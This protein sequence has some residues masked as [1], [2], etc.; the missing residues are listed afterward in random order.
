MVVVAND[1]AAVAV[2]EA[3]EVVRSAVVVVSDAVEPSEVVFIGVV[4][5]N[6][7]SIV[8]AV[9]PSPSIQNNMSTNH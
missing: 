3:L 9:V 5:C 4:T 1:E 8:V 2:L 7:L 6:V